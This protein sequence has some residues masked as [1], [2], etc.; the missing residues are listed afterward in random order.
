MV[1]GK[2]IRWEEKERNMRRTTEDGLHMEVA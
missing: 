2:D 1:D